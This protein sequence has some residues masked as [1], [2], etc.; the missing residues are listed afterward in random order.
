MVKILLRMALCLSLLSVAY[1]QGDDI[2]LTIARAMAKQGESDQAIEQ[3]RSY[4]I[5]KPNDGLV[6]LALA[7]VYEDA[8][9][10]EEG[11]SCRI[12]AASLDPAFAKAIKKPSKKTIP[13]N[14]PTQIKPKK[15]AIEAS[16]KP[17]LFQEAVSLTASKK[18]KQA[19]VA[20]RK[21]LK[22]KPGHAGAYYYA[23]IVRYNMKQKDKA[24]YNLKKG[25]KYP[26]EGFKA[27]YFL[28]K[29]AEGKKNNKAAIKYY[30]AFVKKSPQ[31]EHRKDAESR[32]KVLG[33]QGQAVDPSKSYPNQDYSELK[34]ESMD[35]ITTDSASKDLV[36][37]KVDEDTLRY[38]HHSL[39]R[40]GLFSVIENEIPGHLILKRAWNLYKDGQVNKAIELLREAQLKFP[41]S[42]VSKLAQVNLISLYSE[43]GLGDPMLELGKHLIKR[44]IEEPYRSRASL[45]LAQEYLGREDL[46]NTQKYLG[47]INLNSKLKGLPSV[48]NVAKVQALYNQLKGDVVG[49]LGSLTQALKKEDDTEEK[50]KIHLKIAKILKDSSLKKARNHY[51]KSLKLCTEKNQ[52]VCKEALIGVADLSFKLK[53]WA[54]AKDSYN[55]YLEL[56]NDSINSPW[57]Q[58]QIG[59][60]FREQGILDEAIRSY[61]KVVETWSKNYWAEQAHWKKN[62]VV[63]QKQY[64]QV[65]SGHGK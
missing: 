33:A 56:E 4:L 44:K 35:S 48:S 26:K 9:K 24:A 53:D 1:A 11:K 21:Y 20:W 37:K 19:I 16:S 5:E 29:I 64:E 46:K 17:G 34:L 41:G 63:W 23:G 49:E 25:L 7:Q 3:Y 10:T 30:Q 31:G 22:M 62:D 2:R 57:S 13:Q 51:A 43:L 45:L 8:G 42:K 65:L 59:N 27:N 32:L 36:E 52:M 12:K 40:E 39:N 50:Q 55:Q 6:W 54:I 15:S 61:E 28:G 18:N 14:S 58:Y 47:K 60:I 38:L